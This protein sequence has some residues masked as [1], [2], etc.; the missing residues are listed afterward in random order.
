MMLTKLN[1]LA[2][3]EVGPMTAMVGAARGCNW[4][5][6]EPDSGATFHMSH[7]RAGMTAYQKAS[8][9]TTAEVAD[10]NIL[11]VYGFGTLEVD[12]DQLGNAAKL[13]RMGAVAY[14]PGLLRNLLYTL[15]AVEQ[16][17]NRL[18]TTEQRLTLGF[19]GEESLVQQQA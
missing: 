2:K 13:V 1:V 3:S 9:G 4:K 14:V 18:Y 16:Y 15:K 5:E 17:G 10:G 11:P 7:T 6:C 12:L 19:L 8:P